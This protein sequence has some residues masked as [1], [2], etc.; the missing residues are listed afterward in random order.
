MLKKSQELGCSN[1]DALCLCKNVAFG[2]GIRDCTSESCPSGTDVQKVY[3]YGI[4]Y[5]AAG[6]LHSNDLG[7]F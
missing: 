4:G 6:K 2:N 5:C 3:Q 1:T 7:M